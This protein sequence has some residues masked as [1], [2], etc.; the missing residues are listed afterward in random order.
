[1]RP[2]NQKNAVR[3]VAD[4][5]VIL[6]FPAL[7][8]LGL[9]LLLPV[10]LRQAPSPK[11]LVSQVAQT[12][13]VQTNL[14]DQV[15]N[16]FRKQWVSSVNRDEAFYAALHQVN[17]PYPAFAFENGQ[18]K[19]WSDHRFDLPIEQMKSFYLE[20]LIEGKNGSLFL[21]KSTRL[22][23]LQVVVLMPLKVVYSDERSVL[24][25]GLNR[26]IFSADIADVA[27]AGNDSPLVVSSRTEGA[28]S[29]ALIPAEQAAQAGWLLWF[30][31][32][33]DLVALLGALGLVVFFTRREVQRKRYVQAI[34]V[35]FAGLATL[36]IIMLAF[37]WPYHWYE[38]R[39]FS[40][41]LFAVSV[42][43]PS[44]GDY[45]LNLL[46]LF[47]VTT[48]ALSYE[49]KFMPILFRFRKST[50]M[51]IVLDA[52]S[53][54]VL[55]GVEYL[56]IDFFRATRLH[57]V[58]DL[59]YHWQLQGVY[60]M[61]IYFFNLGQTSV[62]FSMMLYLSG[63][64]LFLEQFKK[65][66]TWLLILTIIITLAFIY[67]VDFGFYTF[68][69]F[70]SIISISYIN[71][72]FSFRK[73][74]YNSFLFIFISGISLAFSGMLAAR[75]VNEEKITVAKNK[76][77]DDL[78]C[79]E[80][81]LVENFLDK[82][83][84]TA[85]EEI[86]SLAYP[87]DV[88]KRL[89]KQL[90]DHHQDH[91][92]MQ[93][94]LFAYDTGHVYLSPLDSQFFK[95]YGNSLKPSYFDGV[96]AIRPRLFGT[97]GYLGLTPLFGQKGDTLG[98]LAIEMQRR[99]PLPN[100]ITPWFVEEDY[101]NK[102]AG[103]KD[104]SY[105]VF[106]GDSLQASGGDFA[107]NNAFFN[108]I[109]SQPAGDGNQITIGM[110]HH[111]IRELEQGVFIVVGSMAGQWIDYLS[112]LSFYFLIAVFANLVFVSFFGLPQQRE[113]R[114]IT[115]TTKIQFYLNL[116]F[117]LPFAAVLAIMVGVLRE[118]NSNETELYYLEKAENAAANLGAKLGSNPGELPEQIS[119]TL[120]EEVNNTRNL[121]N[122][123]ISLFGTDGRLIA[124]SQ[125]Y[126]FS[127]NMLS[128]LLNPKA[129]T[130]LLESQSGNTVLEEQIAGLSYQT[131]Y[132]TVKAPRTGDV[133]GI[134]ALPFHGTKHRFD[135]QF[136]QVIS[137]VVKVFTVTFAGLLTV[138]FLSAKSLTKPLELIR[139]KI[140]KTS[141]ETANQP[142]DYAPKDEFGM[143]VQA[144]N[145]MLIKLQESKTALARSE[146]ESA[147]REMA[148]QVAHEIKNPLTPMKL[149][150]QHLHRILQN[151]NGF[152]QKS[153]KSLLVQVETLNDIATSFSMYA[154]MPAPKEEVVDL[155][156][157]IIDAATLYEQKCELISDIDEGKFLIIGDEKL[158]GRVF[159]N[160][161]INGIQS[162]PEERKPIINISLKK[163]YDQY[164][165]VEVKDNG[166]GIPEEYQNKVFV[167][168]FTTKSEGSG[169]GLAI[170]KRSIEHLGGSIWFETEIG[171]GT[172]FFVEMPL[173]NL[174]AA[175]AK[176]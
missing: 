75:I 140:R 142:I 43:A 119:K 88:R 23:Y 110:H 48:F 6:G 98:Y 35:L 81:F 39:L 52:L 163:E 146:K 27:P 154:R 41:E 32:A 151:E 29:L 37:G 109:R 133:L 33:I 46:L 91:Y 92:Q 114:R 53:V 104:F 175:K 13:E 9:A 57:S 165:R 26:E 80:D 155:K 34:A 152:A 106:A 95:S 89:N 59:D 107:Y 100:G 127:S 86:R 168:D 102:S 141:F 125:P 68:V 51:L 136:S 44:L 22:G 158:L 162:V 83:M 14:I 55:L 120:A 24:Q 30:R 122:A 84:K 16:D 139:E 1:M 131:A 64:L 164:V 21:A 145:E 111:L 4:K 50:L 132:A 130:Y 62:I 157:I 103:F 79:D 176:P 113:W 138:L 117:L 87:D 171:V 8:L 17:S 56:I 167:P 11:M 66:Y 15:L 38:S 173:L 105:A 40:P 36:R 123:D 147:W 2:L 129:L 166:S 73:L 118:S 49:G 134:V 116:A 10:N 148:R 72:S 172:S 174:Q 143:L 137:N 7:I 18:L 61:A 70:F 160:L 47:I 101:Y 99:D 65:R 108:L 60:E 85:S 69:I 90:L 150:L 94:E 126:L 54:G 144:Y 153:L 82:S 96:F 169:I 58:T 45:T 42:I 71:F 63:R 115:F 170:S 78:I 3:L 76:F 112:N 93:I 5:R 77:I 156:N 19:Y 128:G 67:Q 74:D 124:S 159:G 25:S 135:L 28:Y 161:I 20:R 12:L 149:N 121:L 97:M 31:A